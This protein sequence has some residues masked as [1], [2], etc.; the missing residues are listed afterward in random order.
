MIWL[1]SVSALCQI[2]LTTDECVCFV[3]DLADN[4]WVCQLCVRFGWQLIVSALCQIWLTTD[5]CVGFV[6]DLADNWWMCQLRTILTVSWSLVS[7]SFCYLLFCDSIGARRSAVDS[8]W[9]KTKNKLGKFRNAL[10]SLNNRGFL[11][12]A[13][14]P[15]PWLVKENNMVKVERRRFQLNNL[16]KDIACKA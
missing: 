16:S 11:V 14:W 3:S 12:R 7:D 4:W 15:L 10:P 8:V 6:S 5:E 13:I 9:A 1:M 2:W